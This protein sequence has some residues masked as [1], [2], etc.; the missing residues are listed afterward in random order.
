MYFPGPGEYDLTG[1]GAPDIC[2]YNTSSAPKTTAA[3]V[4][5]IQEIEING[6]YVKYTDGV[7]LSDGEHGFLEKHRLLDRKFDES[8]DYLY[9][10]PRGDRD[11]NKNLA[12]NP[13]W[14]D[15]LN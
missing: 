6:K 4:A 12:Q 8:R 9:P 3:T 14:N 10:I 5:Q 15:G 7:V 13:G 2:L 11:L 1:D